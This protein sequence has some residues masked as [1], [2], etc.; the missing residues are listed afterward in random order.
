MRNI[1]M[2][3]PEDCISVVNRELIIKDMSLCTV[4]KGIRKTRVT[5]KMEALSIYLKRY[6]EII[7]VSPDLNEGE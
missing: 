3:T 4:Y 5:V 2:A 7:D 6:G 1:L